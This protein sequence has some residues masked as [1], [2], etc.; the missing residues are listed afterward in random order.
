MK[1]H[2]GTSLPY[3]SESSYETMLNGAMTAG[4]ALGKLFNLVFIVSTYLFLK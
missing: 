3:G 2:V 4:D 1:Q